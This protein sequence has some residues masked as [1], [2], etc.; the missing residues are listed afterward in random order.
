VPLEGSLNV[1]AAFSEGHRR[2]DTE[3]CR[4][5]AESGHQPIQPFIEDVSFEEGGAPF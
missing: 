5:V 3:A 2:R 1:V 4:I